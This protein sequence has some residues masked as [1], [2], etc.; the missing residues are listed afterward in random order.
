MRPRALALLG[1]LLAVD[2]ACQS[3]TTSPPAVQV[4]EDPG[5]RAGAAL[6]AGRY[7]EAIGLYHEALLRTPDSVPL[8]YGL[9]V[10]L[11]YSDRGAATREFLWVLESA[12]PGSPEAVESRAWLAR[13]GALP[14][15]AFERAT[16][17]EVQSDS[18]ALFGRA[19]FAEKGERP[20]PMRRMQL[21]LVGQ[22]NTPTK[23]ERYSLR[24]DEDGSFKFSGVVPGPYMLTN[25]V[26][27]E[28]TWRLR[29][30]LKP[31]EEKQLELGPGN[32]TQAQDDFPQPR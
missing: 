4:G 8:R 14:Q 21:F 19:I 17:Q 24:T 6:A 11:S 13:A 5:A 25:R 26:A 32:S 2:T 28:P 27:G 7:A 31:S 23:E 16:N 18:S 30:E 29:V 10:A 1:L 20:Q 12:P 9:A 22:P 15:T 3:Q